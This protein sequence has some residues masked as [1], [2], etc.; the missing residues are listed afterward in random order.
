MSS[1][2]TVAGLLRSMARRGQHPAVILPGAAGRTVWSYAA[3][4]QDAVTLAR[5][6]REAGLRRA[7]PV[8]LWAPNSPEWIIAALAIMAAGGVLVAIDDLSDTAQLAAALEASGARLLFATA[9]HLEAAG[10]LLRA[11][12]VATIQLDAANVGGAAKPGWP[13]PR[14]G[15]GEELPIPAADDPAVLGWTSG[16]TGAAKGFFLSYRNIGSNVE[17]L[18]Q[19]DIV[20]QDDRVLLPLPLHHAYPFVVG[21]LTPLTIGATIVLPAS[22]TGPLIMQ[23]L[24]DGEV[25]TIVGVPRLYEAMLAAIGGRVASHGRAARAIWQSLLRLA[26]WTRRRTGLRP[27]RLWF[28]P[29]RRG[30]A[31]RLRYLVC[32]GARLET[33]IEDQLEALGWTVLV[34]YGLAETASLFTGNPPRERR[35]GSAG[36]PLAGGAIRIDAPDAEGIGAIELRGPSIMAG[37]LN[38]PQANRTSFTPD[39]WFRTGDVGRLDR[40][41]FLYVTGRSKEIL[42]L[43][44]GKKINPE[45]LE[46]VYAGAPQIREIALLEE[47]G[48][49]VALVRPD[50]ARIRAMGTL[51][52]RDGVR[53]VLAEA[54]RQLPPYQRPAGFALTDQPLPRTRLGKYRRFLLAPLYR[55]A[56]GEGPRRA[57][58]PLG[59]DDRALLRDPT[60]GAVWALLRERYPEQAV[61][62]D[63]TLGLELNLDSF[64]WMALAIALQ[65]RCGVRLNEA[66]IAAIDTIRDLLRRC[67]AAG[68]RQ[69]ETAPAMQGEAAAIDPFLAPTGPLLTLLGVL[70][71]AINWAVMRGLFRLRVTGRDVLPASGAFVITPN[72][73][74]YLDPLMIAA[75]LPLSRLRRT[76]W[77]GTVALLFSTGLRRLFSRAAHVFPVDEH[78][79]DAAL[80]ACVAVLRAGHAAVWFPEGWR[81]PD[82]RLQRFLPGIGQI[83]LRAGVPAVPARITGTLAAWPRGQRLPRLARVTVAF[84]SA[85]PVDALRAAG[86]GGTAAERV[87]QALRE[88]VLALGGPA[89]RE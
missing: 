62:L 67:A 16:T 5:G 24:R 20:N 82:G 8:A 60:A 39:G 68:P 85:A 17:A 46:R 56:L 87:A 41:G 34:G 18:R 30:V 77:A 73:V 80:V 23:A 69:R 35:R 78:R 59:P 66:D 71:Y 72:H 74:S 27:G 22:A 33:G 45:E 75:A 54:A 38:D 36:K 1:D 37:Y 61:D 48:A 14:G 81:S 25:T 6:L 70:L 89:C 83:L 58:R 53:V 76:Y 86:T 47:R 9:S 55:Q 29:V 88:R 4:A 57:A 13:T 49:L 44:G 79:P 12:G 63:V 19:L 42:V 28:A 11:K 15:S 32:G 84:A 3:L 50:P 64:G 51:N 26:I 31:P 65:E 2:W 10:D 43:G 52:L 40:A 7:Q 21:T